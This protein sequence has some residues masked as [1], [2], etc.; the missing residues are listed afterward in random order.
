MLYFTMYYFQSTVDLNSMDGSET[1][2]NHGGAG[3]RLDV[4]EALQDEVT[5]FNQREK[6]I[7]HF[8]VK[9]HA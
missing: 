3:I 5:V 1:A 6:L 9:R 2:E 8:Q 4:K 7:H